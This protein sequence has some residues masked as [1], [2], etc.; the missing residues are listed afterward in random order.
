MA[1]AEL[2][3]PR[4][5]VGQWDYN[6]EVHFFLSTISCLRFAAGHGR[7]LT[8]RAG[9]LQEIFFTERRGNCDTGTVSIKITN[10]RNFID[11]AKMV[12][13]LSTQSY[14]NKTKISRIIKP[15]E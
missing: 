5:L 2:K 1:Q 3:L 9:P 14:R 7:M 12:E 13:P 11:G 4:P 6:A 15:G 10:K 8:D